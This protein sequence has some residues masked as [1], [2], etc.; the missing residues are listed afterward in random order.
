VVPDVTP[1]EEGFGSEL[2]GV[3][4]SD[5]TAKASEGT[6]ASTEDREMGSQPAPEPPE[7]AVS[8]PTAET[9]AHDDD[10]ENT[11]DN[12]DVL[13][14]PSVDAVSPSGDEPSLEQNTEVMDVSADVTTPEPDGLER[15]DD[16]VDEPIDDSV[17]D[18]DGTVDA[19]SL[20]EEEDDH[21]LS[22]PATASRRRESEPSS[23]EI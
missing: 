18:V 12:R 10:A 3:T 2:T 22:P 21:V 14:R 19:E 4:D 6:K 11:L 8:S 17:M 7:E 23:A 1:I 16:P 9:R 15:A 13:S 20:K 5:E